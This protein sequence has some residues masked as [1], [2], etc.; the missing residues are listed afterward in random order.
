MRKTDKLIR[1]KEVREYLEIILGIVRIVVKIV[2][3]INVLK[4]AL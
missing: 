4:L 2:V 1:L 3:L